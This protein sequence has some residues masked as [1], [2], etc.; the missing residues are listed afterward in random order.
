MV[1][2]LR[3]GPF[4]GTLVPECACGCGEIVLCDT[5]VDGSLALR[6]FYARSKDEDREGRC[7]YDYCRA[8]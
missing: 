8:P 4:D 5:S 3:G 1:A 6:Y 2:V 7:V